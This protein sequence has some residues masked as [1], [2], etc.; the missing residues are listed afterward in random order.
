MIDGQLLELPLTANHR[1][2][3]EG[4]EG[5]KEQKR[6]TVVGGRRGEE[7]IRARVCDRETFEEGFE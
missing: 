6:R 5:R 1:E 7:T 2:G 3:R 4:E